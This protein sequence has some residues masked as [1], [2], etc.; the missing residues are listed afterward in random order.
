MGWVGGYVDGH[1]R[2]ISRAP[3]E[4]IMKGEVMIINLK[5]VEYVRLIYVMSTIIL[6]LNWQKGQF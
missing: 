2:V 3:V 6:I 1:N 5:D 4:L